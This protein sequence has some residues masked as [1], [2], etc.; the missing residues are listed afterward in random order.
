MKKH[1]FFVAAG[2][3]ALISCGD[4]DKPEVAKL[5]KLTKVTCYLNNSQTP[6]YTVEINYRD[7]GEIANMQKNQE[8]RLQFIYVGNTLTVG[9]AGPETVEYTLK[10]HAI[11]QEK[12]SVENS[13]ANNEIY[14]SDEYLYKYQGGNLYTADWTTRWPKKDGGGYETRSYTGVNA[15]VYTWERGNVTR[16]TQDKKEMVYEYGSQ[17]RPQNF[18]LRVIASFD[19]TVFGAFT[20]V[21]LLFGNQI[22]NLPKRAYWYM[23]PETSVLYAEYEYTYDTIIGDYITAMTIEETNHTPSGDIRNTYTYKFEYDYKVK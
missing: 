2:L 1:L 5:D 4:D 16:L 6:L 22:K 7:D 21:N 20:P 17:Q 11:T 18:P 8:D 14:V 15:F 23:V 3:M 19:P 10:G 9:N 12:V 13:Y